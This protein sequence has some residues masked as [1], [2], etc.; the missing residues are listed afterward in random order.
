MNHEKAIC[1]HEI[2]YTSIVILPGEDSNLS[3][4]SEIFSMSELTLP[5][6]KY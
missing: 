5:S 4:D 6:L 3:I 2:Q 1:S